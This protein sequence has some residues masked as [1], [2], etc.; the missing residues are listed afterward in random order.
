MSAPHEPSPSITTARLWAPDRLDI[1]DLL[2]DATV[3]GSQWVA[4]G[5]NEVFLLDLEDSEA[6]RGLAIYKPQRGE[7][8]LWDFPSGS[9]YRREVASYQLSRFL[10]WP[11][12]P[13]TIARDG[14]YGVGALQ[15]FV[16]TVSGA[17]YFSFR[18]E[19]VAEVQAIAVFDLLT[20]NADR[21]AGHCLLGL[22]G[23]VW[24]IDHGL[25]FHVEPKLRT[26]IWDFVGKPL[27]ERLVADVGRLAEALASEPAL[28]TGLRSLLEAAEIR[29]LERRSQALIERPV[30]P[31]PPANRRSVPMP[32][33]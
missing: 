16:P 4:S 5:S 2:A 30:F 9:L 13:P 24:A 15:C 3:I 23:R 33:I 27:P 7:A 22:D 32:M 14:P 25:T 29:S 8:P 28:A 26:V 21:K 1:L 17:H 31:E 12:I 11:N 6:G 20:N 10:G 18:E 19:R